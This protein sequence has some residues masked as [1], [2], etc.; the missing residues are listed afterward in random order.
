MF[1]HTFSNQGWA[2]RSGSPI[3]AIPRVYVN[4]VI[5]SSCVDMITKRVYDSHSSKQPSAGFRRGLV[6]SN[7]WN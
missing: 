1:F 2:R 6:V 5:H 4:K 7:Y 3:L